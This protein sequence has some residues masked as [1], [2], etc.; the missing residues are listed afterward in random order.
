[1]KKKLITCISQLKIE[2]VEVY[3]E[4]EKTITFCYGAGGA[5]RT[6]IKQNNLIIFGDTRDEL[7]QKY[8]EVQQKEIE[9][10]KEQIEILNRQITDIQKEIDKLC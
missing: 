7:I 6:N 8:K 3:K 9:K 4:T 10:L 5:I 2:S 1:M